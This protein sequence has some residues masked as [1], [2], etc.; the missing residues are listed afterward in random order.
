M[1]QLLLP[2]L[3]QWQWVALLGCSLLLG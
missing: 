2:S 3:A 1:L